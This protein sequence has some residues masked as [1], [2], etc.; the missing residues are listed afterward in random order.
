MKITLTVSELM[1]RGL[2]DLFCE[3]RGISVWAAN[4]GQI[5]SDEEC[6]FTTPTES[7]SDQERALWEAVCP[8]T[9]V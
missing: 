4:E 8:K 6:S 2:W 3:A 5:A 7:T 9:Y 1:D